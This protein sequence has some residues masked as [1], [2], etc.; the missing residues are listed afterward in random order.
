MNISS[1]LIIRKKMRGFTLVEIIISITLMAIIALG[2]AQYMIYARWDVDR[3]IRRQLAW[4]NMASR[5]EQAVDY[6][7][8]TVA[9]SLPESS[10]SVTISGLQAYRTTIVTAIDDPIDG[11]YPTDWDQ[12]DY[13]KIQIYISW[14]TPGN[15]SD[16]LTAYLSDETSWAY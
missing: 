14:F 2:T 10:K 6:G 11:Y 12:P 4:I 16:S 15:V 7:Y 1:S 5:M 3:A 13:Y 8:S 9:S